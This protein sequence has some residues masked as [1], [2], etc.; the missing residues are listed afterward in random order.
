MRVGKISPAKLLER[1]TLPQLTNFYI[2][3]MEYALKLQRESL[4]D[5][6]AKYQQDGTPVQHGTIEIYDM[7][8]LSFSQLNIS[9]LNALSSVLKIGQ[10]HYPENLWKGFIVNAP[11]VF[12]ATWKII[13][14]ILHANTQAKISVTSSSNVESLEPLYGA[15]NIPT[16]LG[17]T[18]TTFPALDPKKDHLEV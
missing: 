6:M 1:F 13:K 7:A 15:S 12:S 17:G 18:D 4:A 14:P 9:A 16:F 8:G 10:E 11:V 3:W 2:F 5:K